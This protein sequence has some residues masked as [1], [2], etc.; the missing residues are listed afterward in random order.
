MIFSCTK[1]L[2]HFIFSREDCFPHQII[3]FLHASYVLH[4][5]VTLDH[6]MFSIILV[7]ER[8]NSDFSCYFLF[9]FSNTLIINYFVLVLILK[10]SKSHIHRN[11]IEHLFPECFIYARLWWDILWYIASSVCLSRILQPSTI[12][13]HDKRK[14]RSV[15]IRSRSYCHIVGKRCR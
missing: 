2:K 9:N 11:K 15:V 4:E 13:L 6:S 12:D 7:N 8:H 5:A 14:S 10:C 1:K 3:L